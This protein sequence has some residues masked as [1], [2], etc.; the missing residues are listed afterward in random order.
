VRRLDQLRLGR[1]TVFIGAGA[2]LIGAVVAACSTTKDQPAAS[3]QSGTNS[4]VNPT[5]PATTTLPAPAPPK[6][7]AKTT[8]VPL[9]S[10]VI[11][12][13]VVLSQPS[14]GIFNGLSAIC[15]HQ[16]CTVS[17]VAGGTIECPCHGSRFNLDGLVA[18]G[19]ATRPLTTKSISVQGDSIVLDG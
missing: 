17:K 2:G 3:S 9:G 14:Q 8:Q 1:R 6:V 15:T 4:T 12:D 19:P 11:I 13:D 16:G 10:G 7:I 5:A 18:N